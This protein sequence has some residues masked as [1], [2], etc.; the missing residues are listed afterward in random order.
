MTK[1]KH[2]GRKPHKGRARGSALPVPSYD[3]SLLFVAAFFQQEQ[4]RG[5][6]KGL[7]QV[8]ERGLLDYQKILQEK[9]QSVVDLKNNLIIKFVE[10]ISIPSQ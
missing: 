4:R 8:L 7:L 5:P 3:G 9:N 10:D 1:R 6:E 2:E